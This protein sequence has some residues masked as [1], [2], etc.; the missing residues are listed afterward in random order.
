MANTRTAN[1][2]YCDTTASFSGPLSICSLKY[3]GAASGTAVITATDSGSRLWE[4][5]GASNLRSDEVEIQANDGITVTIAS[6]AKVY[7][8]LEA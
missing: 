6:G 4:E 2:I 8:Y 5:A 7:I 1:V 3:I